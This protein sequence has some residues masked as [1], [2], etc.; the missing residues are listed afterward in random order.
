MPEDHSSVAQ[1]QP[2][3]HARAGR[4][5]RSTMGARSM[6]WRT[7]PQLRQMFQQWSPDQRL[8]QPDAR[9]SLLSWMKDLAQRASS[10]AEANVVP[11]ATAQTTP[12]LGPQDADPP[13]TIP[14][15]ALNFLRETFVSGGLRSTQASSSQASGSASR[16]PSSRTPR[17]RG[18]QGI[19]EQAGASEVEL[20]Q[21]HGQVASRLV[22]QRIGIG[23]RLGAE[24]NTDGLLQPLVNVREAGARTG[25]GFED[26]DQRVAADHSG[27]GFEDNDQ[28][29]SADHFCPV[30]REVVNGE[31]VVCWCC[32]RSFCQSCDN[33][34]VGTAIEAGA[35]TGDNVPCP[36]CREP[37]RVRDTVGLARAVSG[38][39]E[40]STD[41]AGSTELY[42]NMQTL[43][44]LPNFAV[45]CSPNLRDIAKPWVHAFLSHRRRGESDL[46]EAFDVNSRGVL[47]D[48]VAG[49]MVKGTVKQH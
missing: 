30:C 4:G 47:D 25:I 5:T 3:R 24:G 39:P 41:A 42:K 40:F 46:I 9:K 36:C 49:V 1:V 17:H 38:A 12:S 45:L 18:G 48:S 11:D 23:S 22:M 32:N 29:V 33:Q 13:G 6:A 2:R 28:R 19:H 10:I 16:R 37:R 7:A 43:K 21:M 35:E 8:S 44:K 20:E 27:I 14:N 34:M 15:I 31:Q 26:N